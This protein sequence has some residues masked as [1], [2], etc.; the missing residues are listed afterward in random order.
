VEATSGLRFNDFGNLY[1]C[2]VLPRVLEHVRLEVR[3]HGRL[4]PWLGLAIMKLLIS[5]ITCSIIP[6][7]AATSASLALKS[8]TQRWAIG[9]STSDYIGFWLSRYFCHQMNFDRSAKNFH[10]PYNCNQAPNECCR[11]KLGR[12]HCFEN[13]SELVVHLC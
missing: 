7:T 12:D 3:L 4:Q 9:D 11:P 5:A 2:T 6:R 8:T 10:L 1:R 13:V